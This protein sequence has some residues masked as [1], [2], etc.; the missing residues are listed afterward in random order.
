MIV[1][2]FAIAISVW[3]IV[4]PRSMMRLMERQTG[5]PALIGETAWRVSGVTMLLVMALIFMFA[6]LRV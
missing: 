3:W 2:V 6:Y 4:A 5:A 1:Y